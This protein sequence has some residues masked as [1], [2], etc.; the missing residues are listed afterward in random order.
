[1]YDWINRSFFL[2]VPTLLFAVVGLLPTAAIKGRSFGGAPIRRWLLEHLVA[3]VLPHDAFWSF[4]A[5][6][7]QST[8]HEWLVTV[9][10]GLNV[11][12]VLLPLLYIVGDTLSRF[13]GYAA[14]R[15]IELKRAAVRRA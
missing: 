7:A 15:D 13:S 14:R 11:N 5:W 6:F 9:L 1:M 12:A 8:L 4:S 3:P 2:F 10:V